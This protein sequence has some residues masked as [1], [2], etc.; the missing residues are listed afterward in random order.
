MFS[1][2]TAHTQQ[3]SVPNGVA[4]HNVTVACAFTKLMG[5]FVTFWDNDAG[6]K[7]HLLANPGQNVAPIGAATG[8]QPPG[9]ARAISSH[10]AA[11]TLYSSSRGC[12][13]TL[14]YCPSISRCAARRCLLCCHAPQRLP[15]LHR[16]RLGLQRMLVHVHPGQALHERAG[17]QQPG[18]RVLDDPMSGSKCAMISRALSTSASPSRSRR[19]RVVSAQL[20]SVQTGLAQTSPGGNVV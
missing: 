9:I 8:G 4:E 20:Y 16:P 18:G 11:G 6:S 14:L 15:G 1:Y 19:G 17:L 2:P 7:I 3:S 12:W 5:V 10:S 13:L